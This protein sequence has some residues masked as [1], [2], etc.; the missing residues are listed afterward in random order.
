M[1]I[2]KSPH[3]KPIS[4]VWLRRDL[5]LNDHAALAHA[6]G[7]EGNIQPVFV[8]DTDIL[9]DFPNKDDRRVTF[10]AEALMNIH[11]ELKKHGGE[12]LVLHGSAKE[13]IPQT[14]KKLGAG[15]VYLAA[16]YEPETRKRDVAVKKALQAQDVELHAVC[17]HLIHPPTAVL[18]GDG[19]PYKVFT[20][21]SKAWKAA[22][23]A[24][25]FGEY[26]VKL[27]GRL[28]SVA[29]EKSLK[30]TSAKALVEQIGYHYTPHKAWD[31]ADG[32]K[33]L[34]R[35]I[36]QGIGGYKL[37]RDYMADEEGT[38]RISPYLR[39]G[40]VSI[41]HCARLA[42]EQPQYDTWLGELIWREFYAM[43]LYHF[44]NTAHE[45]FLEKYRGLEWSGKE[46]HWQA[47]IECRTGYPIV[48]AAMT[49]LHEMGWMHNRARM[50]VASFL[51]KDLHIDWRMGDAHFAEWLMDYDMA[52][53]VGGWQWAASTGTDA[54]PYFRIFNP[55]SQSQ[56]FDPKGEYIRHWLPELK[57]LSDKEIHMPGKNRPKSYPAPIVDHDK[58]RQVTLAAYK[59]R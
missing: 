16:D 34:K 40:L 37:T 46:S 9:K 13:L 1:S 18:K 23:Q 42:V 49:E 25:S 30:L 43:I 44:P 38:S 51:T 6:L 41:R 57:D 33:R 24:D 45:E 39:F 22:L 32:E 56:R 26:K 17:D 14:A 53:N 29:G 27:N 28:A 50:I 35:F 8:F 10:I 55:V 52:S 3:D 54:V 7:G 36:R 58:E 15:A 59:G 2:T 4:L 5:R 48:D 12:L 11:A 47:F 21:Y 31:A 20:P 19:T